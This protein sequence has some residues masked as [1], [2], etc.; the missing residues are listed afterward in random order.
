MKRLNIGLVCF[1]VSITSA[2]CKEVDPVVEICKH[3]VYVNFPD[4]SSMKNITATIRDYSVHLS[5]ELQIRTNDQ[6]SKHKAICEFAL[7]ETA[8][9]LLGGLVIDD[10]RLPE[11]K[12]TASLLL[13]IAQTG[14]LRIEPSQTRLK[15]LKLNN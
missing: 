6:P 10:E 8:G 4:G 13:A 12:P 15:P 14:I 5:F 3:A 1:A 9:I 11:G 7:T 2:S